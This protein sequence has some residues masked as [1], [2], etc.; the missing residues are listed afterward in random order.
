MIFAFA[1]V[2]ALVLI[3]WFY[4]SSFSRRTDLPSAQTASIS[5][6]RAWP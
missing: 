2:A 5:H 3:A 6:S 1:P 4:A